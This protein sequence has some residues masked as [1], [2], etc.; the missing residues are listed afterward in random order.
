MKEIAPEQYAT[1]VRVNWLKEPCL[2]I[3]IRADFRCEYCGCDLLASV[4]NL[5]TLELDHILPKS[6]QGPKDDAANL[7][8]CCSTCNALKFTYIPNGDSREE[9]VA[10]ASRH[11]RELRKNVEATQNRY[12]E[13]MGR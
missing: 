4:N 8:V 12:R 7:A 6:N 10:D 3:A 5:H 1:L 11:V 9:R 13:L 2:S